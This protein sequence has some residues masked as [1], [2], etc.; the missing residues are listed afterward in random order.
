M[1]T[2]A[3]SPPSLLLFQLNVVVVIVAAPMCPV[4]TQFFLRSSSTMVRG[5]DMSDVDERGHSVAQQLA[6]LLVVG[7]LWL[8]FIPVFCGAAISHRRFQIPYSLALICPLICI[9]VYVPLFATLG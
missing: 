7:C 1:R 3:I 8:L 2:K 9:L 6:L 4:G 5:K